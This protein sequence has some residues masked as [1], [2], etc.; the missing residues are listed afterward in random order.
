M[1]ALLLAAALLLAVPAVAADPNCPTPKP[2]PCE[3][4]KALQAK[5][6]PPEAPVV[7]IVEHRV[8]VTVPGPERVVQVQVPG[9]ERVVE[10]IVTQIVAPKPVGHWLLGGGL[11]W[12]HD[13]GNDS[14]YGVQAVTGY[15]WPKGWELLVGPTW[16]DRNAYHGTARKGCY[17]IPYQIEA[18]NPWGATALVV[19]AF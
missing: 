12:Q 4:L 16:T 2:I 1:K 13:M 18:A 5:R 9:P 10:K 8:E 11:L 6:C 15:R 3:R 17:S 7:K 14:T 19:H